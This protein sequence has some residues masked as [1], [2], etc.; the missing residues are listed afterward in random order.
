MMRLSFLAAPLS[1]VVLVF[2]AK[3]IAACEVEVQ[4]NVTGLTEPLHSAI[5]D[6]NHIHGI[7]LSNV[8][9]IHVEDSEH[10]IQSP[11]SCNSEEMCKARFYIATAAS[12]TD[13][14]VNLNRCDVYARDEDCAWRTFDLRCDRSYVFNYVEDTICAAAEDVDGRVLDNDEGV[15]YCTDDHFEQ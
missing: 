5:F 8:N 11:L 1:V 13:K 14:N 10:I 4:Y 3:T 9:T 12:Y 2:T 7:Q 6:P 15:W